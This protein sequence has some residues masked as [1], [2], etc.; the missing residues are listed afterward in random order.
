MQMEGRCYTSAIS[1]AILKTL[2]RL[3]S[4]SDISFTTLAASLL[5][6]YSF[7]LS[8]FVYLLEADP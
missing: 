3:V 8:S 7:V 4:S 6:P 5:L 1:I 2:T